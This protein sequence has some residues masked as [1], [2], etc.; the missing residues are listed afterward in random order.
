MSN[1]TED[2]VVR[3]EIERRAYRRFCDRGSINGQDL[4]DW[5]AAERELLAEQHKPAEVP[6]SAG[7]NAKH[8]RK[9]TSRRARR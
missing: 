3:Q 2:T 6:G 9:P 7:A 4:D 8:R 5:L 1:P